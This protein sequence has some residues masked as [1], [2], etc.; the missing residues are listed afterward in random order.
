MATKPQFKS[1]ARAGT[2]TAQQL[3]KGIM[4]SAQQIWLAGLGAFSKAQAEGSK[5]FEALVKEGAQ[6]EHKTRK[7]TDARVSEARGAVESTV[8]EARKRAADTWDRLEKV[9]EARVSRALG[10]LGVPGRRDLETLTARVEEL[11]REVRKLNGGERPTAKRTTRVPAKR[12]R[13][14][15]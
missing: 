1:K 2:A 9:F 6:L 10:Q 12:A 8:G 14:S 3:G 4:E 5:L 7:F 11:A 15:A 13:K